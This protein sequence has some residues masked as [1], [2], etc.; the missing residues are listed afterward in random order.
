MIKENILFWLR[1]GFYQA[2]VKDNTVSINKLVLYTMEQ[3][4]IGK[5]EVWNHLNTL[6][7]SGVI[8]LYNWGRPTYQ[9]WGW[10]KGNPQ[11]MDNKLL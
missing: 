7:D 4:K 5:E 6:K 3:F 11:E 9:I 2:W 8:E 1:N 10:Y